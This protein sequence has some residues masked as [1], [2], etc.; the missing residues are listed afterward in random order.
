MKQACYKRPKGEHVTPQ[1]F[2]RRASPDYK[3]LKIF[4]YCP[5]CDQI[6]E[7]YGVH[8][9][10]GPSRF[11]HRNLKDGENP[12]DDCI[13]A[14]RNFRFRG[15]LPGH[16]NEEHGKILRQ[17]FFQEK[18]L[19]QAYSFMLNVCGTGNLP[20]NLFINCIIRADKKKIWSYA[21]IPLW[22]TPYIMLTLE[23]FYIKNNSYPF[24]FYID[25]T[26]SKPLNELWESQNRASLCKVFSDSGKLIRSKSDMPNP[27]KI[28]KENYFKF[29]NDGNWIE[30]FLIKK[31]EKHR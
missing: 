22:A 9:P 1:E 27:L 26:Y 3:A 23:N 19:R 4:P 28:S 13:L 11:D 21:D 2:I 18:N 5:M 31:I 8:S 7:V 24:H 25:K 20:I 12:L 15:M 17:E 16:L 10:N 30:E 14:N 29:S 6:V